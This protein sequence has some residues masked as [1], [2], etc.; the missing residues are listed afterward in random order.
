[1]KEFNE[2]EERPEGIPQS[3]PVDED[4][5]VLPLH[6]RLKAQLVD[7]ALRRRNRRC[8]PH[9]RR[10]AALWRRMTAYA[11]ASLVTGASYS[12]YLTLYQ[13]VRRWRPREVLE[14]GTGISTVVL[15]QALLDN[16][17]EGAPLGRLTSL[18]DDPH[19]YATA[20]AALPADLGGVVDLVNPGKV[21]GHYKIFRGVRYDHVPERDYDFVFSDGP[22]RHS[23]VDGQKL[24][25][26]DLIDVIGRSDRPL[27]AVVDNHYL[28]FYILQ[29]VLGTENARYDVWRR[30]M[31]VG[32]VTRHDLRYLRRE[33]FLPDIRLLGRTRLR[34][35]LARRDPPVF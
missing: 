4:L 10:H 24:F 3:L 7:A 19:W 28:T 21:D 8:E 1:V 34:L 30:L 25:N 12:D 6:V 33:S 9:P 26:L 5:H 15:A 11:R 17:E 16:A 2:E 18:E 14:C 23:P 35:R 27:R 22:D 32:P 13:E 31:F 20:K 29:K